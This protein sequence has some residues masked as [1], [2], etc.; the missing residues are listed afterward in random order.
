MLPT[1]W[2]KSF[3]Q[4]MWSYNNFSEDTIEG[5]ITS[6]LLI[7]GGKSPPHIENVVS[8]GRQSSIAFLKRCAMVPLQKYYGGISNSNISPSRITSPYMLMCIW[9]KRFAR[10]LIPTNIECGSDKGFAYESSLV[11]IELELRVFPFLCGLGASDDLSA[12]M[13]FPGDDMGFWGQSWPKYQDCNIGKKVGEIFGCLEV[14][15][16]AL[17]PLISSKS[18]ISLL[19]SMGAHHKCTPKTLLPPT[20]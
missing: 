13:H 9:L 16:W 8:R 20:A 7:G 6:F 17:I 19:K 14:S 2:A 4:N 18:S 11:Q 3:E 15:N 1:I 10:V 5:A 12:K